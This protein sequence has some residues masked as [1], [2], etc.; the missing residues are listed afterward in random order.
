MTEFKP[1]ELG[2]KELF[3]K[4]FER[5]TFKTYEYAFSTLYLWRDV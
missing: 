4:F 2:D 5:Y 3:N 1:I